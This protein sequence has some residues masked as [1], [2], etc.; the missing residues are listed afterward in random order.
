MDAKSYTELAQQYL[1][2]AVQLSGHQV[3]L[4][5]LQLYGQAVE[6]TLKAFIAK[7]GETPAPI[8][9]LLKLLKSA[10]KHG[11]A[12]TA[13][14]RSVIARLH[15]VFYKTEGGFKYATRYPSPVNAFVWSGHEKTRA[16][17]ES[18]LG[19]VSE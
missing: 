15:E 1:R 17:I 8:H 19:K 9:E 18:L 5:Y 16:T 7:H 14:E 6:L 10:E 2:A 11:L 3:L 12:V 13:S 4:P